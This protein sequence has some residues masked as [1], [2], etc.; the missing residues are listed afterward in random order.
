MGSHFE[1]GGGC[2][3]LFPS[4]CTTDELQH[5]A[6]TPTQP[7]H[8]LK[9]RMAATRLP[10]CRN[11]AGHIH[12][13]SIASSQ[14]LSGR[15]SVMNSLESAQRCCRLAASYKTTSRLPRTKQPSGAWPC[16][17]AGHCRTH[18]IEPH[19]TAVESALQTA[20][21][22]TTHLRRQQWPDIGAAHRSSCWSSITQRSPASV[23]V[24]PDLKRRRVS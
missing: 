15:R 2:A 24:V 18:R 6:P 20:R 3:R 23:C 16:F 5:Y 22:G 7:N 21:N 17:T 10:D 19:T 14:K 11:I 8:E 13:S 12:P 1:R 4:L 9:T